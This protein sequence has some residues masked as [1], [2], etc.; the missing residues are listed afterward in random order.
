MSDIETDR[1]Y[2]GGSTDAVLFLG[3]GDGLVRVTVAGETIGRFGIV[4]NAPILDVAVDPSRLLVAT[5]TETLLGKDTDSLDPT[6]SESIVAVGLTQDG[7]VGADE[8][9]QIF[10][11]NDGQNS[12]IMEADVRAIDPPFIATATGVAHLWESLSGELTDV[13]DVAASP[14]P[15]AATPHGLYRLSDGWT[16]E[17]SGQVSTVAGASDG[18][19]GAVINGT[20]QIQDANRWRTAELPTE[21]EIV[22]VVFG[23]ATYVVTATGTLLVNAGDGWRHRLLG[24]G[25]VRRLA[26]RSITE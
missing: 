14:E 19:V 5:P 6:G 8:A 25:E 16:E 11:V 17:R 15:R 3:T 24:V 2:A 21:E 7:W 23:P 13:R 10:Y 26:V 4:C 18:R 9:G 20:L 22:D 12:V 1:I